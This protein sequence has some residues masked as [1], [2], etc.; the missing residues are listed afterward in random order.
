MQHELLRAGTLLSVVRTRFVTP[1]ML[2]VGMLALGMLGYGLASASHDTNV[3][4][5]CVGA[6]GNL[7]VVEDAADCR[8]N[9]TSLDWSMTGPAGPPGTAAP[10]VGEIVFSAARTDIS[11]SGAFVT[12]DGASARVIADRSRL[13]VNLVSIGRNEL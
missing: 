3:I 8:Q 13:I 11:G 9:E 10:A 12:A 7:R 6:N 5:G 1:S 2:V 4:H